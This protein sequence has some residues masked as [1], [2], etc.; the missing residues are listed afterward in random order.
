MVTRVRQAASEC[1]DAPV[2]G[3]SDAELVGCLEQAWAGVQALTAVVAHLV[4]Q[5]EARGMPGSEAA[6]STVVWLRQRLRMSPGAAARLVALAG[7]LD[8]Q[9][10]VDAA[11]STGSVSVEQAE[12]IAGCVADL[13]ADVGVQVRQE[14]EDLLVGWAG[15]FDA[16]ALGR[17][18]AR[19]LAHV[20]P[21]VADRRD[22]EVL[23]RQ[24]ARAYRKRGLTLS[25]FG[26][27][28]VRLAGWLDAAGAATVHAAID[29]L[30]HPRH[31]SAGTRTP[32]QRRAD[33]LVEVCALALRTAELPAHAG[34]PAQVVVT[35]PVADLM[36]RPGEVTAGGAADIAGGVSRGAAGRGTVI[37]RAASSRAPGGRAHGDRA[38]G[39]RAPGRRAPGDRASSAPGGSKRGG[40]RARSGVCTDR[41]ADLSGGGP[42][43][44]TAADA[45][46]GR[47]AQRNDAQRSDAQRSDA[48][49]NDAQRNDAQRTSA[50]DDRIGAPPG[51]GTGWLDTG[52]PV[53]AAQARQM[54]CDAQ[55]LPAVLG[56]DGQVLDL[57]RARRLITGPLRRALILRDG[58][59][60]F[61]GCD[62]PARWC[63]G[64]HIKA[65]ADGGTSDLA[66]ACLVCA[67]HHRLLHHSDWQVRIAPDGR[68]EFIPPDTVDPQ[69]RPRRNLYHRRQ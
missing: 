62:R 40:S 19:I 22:G 7:A 5:A 53:S 46:A 50:P 43:E 13:P 59:C 60:S 68:P 21:D 14:A 36:S 10:V 29:P 44:D 33:A 24:E 15:Q 51:R 39:D 35:I 61:P 9:P 57:G 2:W 34:D 58:G 54:A 28:S 65:W 52:L 8:R 48:Q 47:S 6:S 27:G 11:V 41:G 25:P 69:R 30:C 31:D 23:R 12:A 16:R 42:A 1:A 26:D 4:R 67:Y 49:R 63:D 32:A 55:I 37:G 18:G 56:T 64:H 45:H 17:L 20:A 66:N 38:P 3:L